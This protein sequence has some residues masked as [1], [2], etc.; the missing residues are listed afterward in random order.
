MFSFFKKK[1]A[2]LAPVPAP[3]PAAVK[4]PAAVIPSAP[5]EPPATASVPARTPATAPVVAGRF[6]ECLET[7]VKTEL[8][9]T[10]T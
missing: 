2:P 3:E 8:S 9:Q 7:L 1:P 10:E 5:G 6:R 4:A